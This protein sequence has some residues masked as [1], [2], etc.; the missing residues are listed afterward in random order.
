M[1]PEVS[2]INIDRLLDMLFPTA[3]AAG[4]SNAVQDLIIRNINTVL[5]TM[6]KAGIETNEVAAKHFN[7]AVESKIILVVL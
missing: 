1:V 3:Y 7:E 6:E 2:V 4:L 5:E